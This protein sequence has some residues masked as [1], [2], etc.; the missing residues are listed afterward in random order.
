LGKPDGP[1][2]ADAIEQSGRQARPAAAHTLG[3]MST[4]APTAAVAGLAEVWASLVEL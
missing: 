2:L 4:E 1:A 3:A